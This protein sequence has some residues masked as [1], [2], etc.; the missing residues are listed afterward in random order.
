MLYNLQARI[1]PCAVNDDGFCIHEI[2]E[3]GFGDE[4]RFRF[5]S[6]E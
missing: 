1:V 2:S 5:V 6:R 4:M 3:S